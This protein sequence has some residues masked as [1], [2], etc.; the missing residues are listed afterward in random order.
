MPNNVSAEGESISV[1]T[2]RAYEASI[3]PEHWSQAAL[4]LRVIRPMRSRY[5]WTA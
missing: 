5:A 1:V 3:Q 4:S 2:S